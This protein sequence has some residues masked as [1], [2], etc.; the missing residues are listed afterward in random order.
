MNTNF[1]ILLKIYRYRGMMHNL[2]CNNCHSHCARALNNANYK[3]KN[4][5]TMIHV[6]WMFMVRKSLSKLLKMK[7]L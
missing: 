6:W 1:K 4:N 2:C 5:Y 3:G 7:H